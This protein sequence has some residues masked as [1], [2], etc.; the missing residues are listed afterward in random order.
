MIMKLLLRLKYITRQ[1][2]RKIMKFTSIRFYIVLFSVFISGISFAANNSQ[3]NEVAPLTEGVTLKSEGTLFWLEFN[4]DAAV[5]WPTFKK[6]WSNEGIGLKSE[7]S[8]LGYMETEWINKNGFDKFRS[9]LLSDKE[10][11]FRERFRLR[12]ERMP[13]N[14]GTRVFIYHTSYGILLDDDVVFSGYL[15]PSPQLELEMLS[16]LALFSGA[17]KAKLNQVVSSYSPAPLIARRTKNNGYEIRMPGTVEFVYKKLIQTLERMD[18]Q[19]EEVDKQ[20]VTATRT[21][22]S[23]I[24]AT[25]EEIDNEEWEIDDSSDLEE[26][27]FS[28]WGSSADKQK[29]AVSAVYG[30]KLSVEGADT[31]IGISSKTSKTKSDEQALKRFS[32]TLARNLKK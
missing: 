27:G 22:A 12:V 4:A 2:V 16:R 25:V 24:G 31:L 7:Q 28:L 3:S 15:S 21:A 20:T 26:S 11:E 6:F 10:P 13:E 1:K 18:I 29:T 30:I 23:S 19:I 17:D 9:V 32:D 14:K 5:L 8:T